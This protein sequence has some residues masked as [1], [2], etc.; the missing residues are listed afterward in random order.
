MAVSYYFQ[1]QSARQPNHAGTTTTSDNVTETHAKANDLI[2]YGN[3]TSVWY[4][5]TNIPLGQSFYN[6]T[7]SVAMVDSY[8][9]SGLGSHYVLA[10]NHVA[11]NSMNFWTLWIFCK[12]GNAW[13]PS[14]WGADYLLIEKGRM[15]VRLLIGSI[16]IG[17]DTLAW[18]YQ[19]LSSTDPS[20]WEPPQPGA[21]KVSQCW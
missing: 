18:Y 14:A 11:Q 20:S 15:E 12:D 1:H 16:S 7:A 3:G 9:S 10:I 2:N 13:A 19:R 4:N 17:T 5:R 21:N 8:Y 6:L